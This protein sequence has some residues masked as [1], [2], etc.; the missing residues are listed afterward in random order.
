MKT[1]IL[2]SGVYA[3]AISACLLNANC[4]V[5]MWT[6]K[7]DFKEVLAREGTYLTNSFEEAAVLK[8]GMIFSKS[9]KFFVPMVK[10]TGSKAAMSTAK[11]G[12]EITA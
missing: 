11:V 5:T 12:P 1:S 3:K 4:T 2:G 7:K 10:P 8:Q 6:E 9:E